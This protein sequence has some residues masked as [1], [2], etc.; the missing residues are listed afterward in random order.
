MYCKQF[1]MDEMTTEDKLDLTDKLV[2][3]EELNILLLTR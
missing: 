1:Y 3:K 2:D